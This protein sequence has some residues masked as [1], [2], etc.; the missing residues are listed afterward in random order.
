[1]LSSHFLDNGALRTI[2]LSSTIHNWHRVFATLI[3]KLVLDLVN[4]CY[5]YTTILHILVTILVNAMIQVSHELSGNG[6]YGTCHKPHGVKHLVMGN[7]TSD[8]L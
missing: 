2:Q 8:K 1:M 4:N 6:A 5:T 7:K 3:P